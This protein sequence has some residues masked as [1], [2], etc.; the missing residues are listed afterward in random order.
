M[1]SR[2]VMINRILIAIMTVRFDSRLF[3]STFR[4]R[5]DF[6]HTFPR[7]LSVSIIL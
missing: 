4:F 2:G 1:L 5:F 6:L 3:D 7:V